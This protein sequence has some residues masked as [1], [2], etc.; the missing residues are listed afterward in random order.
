LKWNTSHEVFVTEIDDEHR[1]IFE[2]LSECQ[3]LFAGG[4]KSAAVRDATDRLTIRI[5]GH[6]AH[7]ERLMRAARYSSLRWHKQLHDAAA[8][9][10]KEF[11][12]RIKQGDAKAGMEMV[13]CLTEWLHN[14]TR[15]ADR[16][17][18]AALRNHQRCTWKVT[19]TAA[20]KPVDACSWVTADGEPFAPPTPQKKI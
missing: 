10:V 17:M 13:E 7:E 14:H 15:I 1:E 11:I 6:F 20:T 19:F 5:A 9:R 12:L 18:G 2:S 16:M 3:T 4:G 8:R